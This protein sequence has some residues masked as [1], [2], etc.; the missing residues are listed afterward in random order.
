LK[1][2][3]KRKL[4]DAMRGEWDVSIR[5]ACGVV[6]MDTS[7]YHY[8]SRR[9]GQAHL[10]QRIREIC[11]TRVRYGYRRVHVLLRREGFAINQKK[12]RRIYR[13]LGL[14]LRNKTPKRKVKAKLRDDR[15]EATRP[16]ETWAMDFVHDQ[17]AMGRKL[18]ILTVVDAFTR[19][20]PV[21]DPRFTYR[22]EDVVQA[23]ERTCR[24]T[25]YPKAI[26]VDQGSEFISRDLDLWAY[27]HDVV[28]DFSRPGKPTD[29][30]YIESF[31][32][33]FR[34]ECLNAHWFMSLEDAH[35][36]MEA[37]RRDYNEVRPHSAIGNKPPIELLNR[38]D[39]SG[40]PS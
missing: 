28:L 32:G 9:P 17:L 1:P 27:Q 11:Q 30:A 7:T 40:P 2:V 36:K 6:E 34:A 25:G 4:V 10:E 33:K 26:R 12:T 20:S 19:F 24:R 39:A 35:E 29:N 23:L 3:R 8:K 21:I 5:R 37:W 38:D 16:N 22:G 15:R 18:R 13:E 14:Q 31:N